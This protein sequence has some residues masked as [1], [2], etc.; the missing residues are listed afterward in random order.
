VSYDWTDK[1]PTAPF[2]TQTFPDGTTNEPGVLL[3]SYGLLNATLEWKNVL[4][5]PLDISVFGTNIANKAYLISNS[6]VFQTIGTQA[7]IYGEPRMFGVR[8]KYHFGG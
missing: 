1:Q 7:V 5:M 6:G 4:Q 2:S 8:L 3:P